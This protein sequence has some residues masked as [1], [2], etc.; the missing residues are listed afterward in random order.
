MNSATVFDPGDVLTMVAPATPDTTLANLA[1]T[2]M[3]ITQ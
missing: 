3:G 2:I 1:W